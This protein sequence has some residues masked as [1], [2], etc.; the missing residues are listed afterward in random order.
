MYYL[1]IIVIDGYFDVFAFKTQLC[2]HKMSM[3]FIKWSVLVNLDSI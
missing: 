2:Q 3:Y 1:G